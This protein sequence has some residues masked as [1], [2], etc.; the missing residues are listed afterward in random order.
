MRRR[1]RSWILVALLVSVAAGCDNRKAAEISTAPAML[2]V[3]PG[4]ENV[5]RTAEYDGT[6]SYRLSDPYPADNTLAQIRTRLESQGWKPD[7]ND[8]MNPGTKN[9]HDRGWMDFIDGTKDDANVFLWA[10]AWQS[11]RGDRVEYWLR[12]EYAKGSGPMS[13]RPP[14]QVSAMY[15]TAPMVNIVRDRSSAP[16]K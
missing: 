12:Y 2:I 4:A 10:A 11:P 5:K 16:R 1:S 9:S 6:V 14:L 13:D 3:L 7:P 15:M 8:I